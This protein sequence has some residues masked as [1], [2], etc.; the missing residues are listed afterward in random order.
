MVSTVA[1]TEA[2]TATAEQEVHGGRAP[3]TVSRRVALAV[4]ALLSAQF[5]ALCLHQAWN[6]SATFDE[7]VYTATAL[8][9]LYD[10]ELRLNNEAPLLPKVV[11]ALPLRLAGVDVPLDGAWAE[12]ETIDDDGWFL[13]YQLAGEFTSVHAE[14]GDLQRVVFASRLMGVIEGVAVG[15]A[16]Y[17]LGATLFS[18]AA[19]LLA[20][21][22]WLTTPL[23]VGFGHISSVDLAF[24]LAVV[25]AALALV[26]HL[27]A[28]TWRTLSV[29]ALAAGALQL[30]RHT[31]FL[32]VAVICAAL[33]VRRWRDG[34]DAARDVAVVL[35]ATWALV[36]VA[37]LAVAPTRVAVEVSD[38]GTGAIAGA[39][40]E[41][42]DVVPWPAEYEAGFQ[43]QLA[44]SAAD[45]QGFLFG[46][47]WWGA[48]P[49]FWP[50]AM[51]VKLP[52]TVV[53]LMIAGPLGWR[54][55][56]GDQ[57]RLAALVAVLPVLAAFAFV[58]PYNK[59]I[60]LRYALPGIVMLLVVASP[61][62][63]GLLRRRAGLAV[64]AGAV[65]AQ[66]AF[67]WGSVPHSLAWTA[68]PFRPGYQVVSESN[69]DWGQDG[70]RLAEWMEGRT[71]HVSYFGGASVVDRV[72][73][74]RPLIGARPAELTGWVAVSASQLT[75]HF[76]DE[77][78]YLRA[79]CNVGTISGTVLLY[80]FDDP[81]TAQPGPEMPAGRCDG[82]VS[83]RVD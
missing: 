11:S 45:T 47:M 37:T 64:L 42:V 46:D 70:Y 1:L 59:P 36:W 65:I 55:L 58:L 27:R 57:R 60:G 72:P 56:N 21:G 52:I 50:L 41:A 40:S 9:T 22:A 79:Y 44:A 31:G 15:L 33:V 74:F 4:L 43:T 14:R 63:L 82:A 10:G 73:G 61:L 76:R 54:R 16:L 80:R 66:L 77:L 39:L 32:Y 51:V 29:L 20:A 81:P 69:L 30:T 75:T 12:A 5:A 18:R 25:A 83:H 48:R 28:P 19:G 78:A 62:A 13:A 53:A 35:V 38:D 23:A 49:A 2:R 34:W 3:L 8:A 71:G 67:L 24:A 17:A 68:P 6:D 7:P 26:R